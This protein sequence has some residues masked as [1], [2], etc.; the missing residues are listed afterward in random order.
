MDSFDA[1]QEK[2]I[3]TIV[4]LDCD[5]S[6]GISDSPPRITLNEDAIPVRKIGLDGHEPATTGSN[7]PLEGVTGNQMSNNDSSISAKQ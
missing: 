3:G 4:K 7:L 1:E 6:Q 2:I 5:G